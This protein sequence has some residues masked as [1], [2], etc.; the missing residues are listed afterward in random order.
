[1]GKIKRNTIVINNDYAEIII[2]TRKQGIKKVKIDIEDIEKIKDFTWCWIDSGT[3]RNAIYIQSTSCNVYNKRIKL[4]RLIMNCPDDKVIDHINRD[5]LDNR[6]SNLKVCKQE[7][8]LHNRTV[9]KNNTS[10]CTGVIWKKRKRK[11]E[12]RITIDYIC[13][14]LG[15]YNDYK[16]AVRARKQILY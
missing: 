12:A 5:T 14:F 11:W 4:H 2:K 15:Y 1:M 16:D 10:G 3:N 13:Y 6:K 9:F 8:N 7:E